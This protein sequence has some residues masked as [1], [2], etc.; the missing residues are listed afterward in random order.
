MR[1][2]MPI[3]RMHAM[4]NIGRDDIVDVEII[5]AAELKRPRVDV[6]ISV[7]GLYRDTFPG[8][9]KRLA[10]AVKKVAALD[11]RDNFVRRNTLALQTTLAHQ[12]VKAEEAATLSTV[13]VFSSQVGQYGNGVSSTATA[14]DT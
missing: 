4:R 10:E 14:S 13:R 9:M 3:G 6:V 11:E 2:K 8:P 5:P 1:G 12:G 7:T